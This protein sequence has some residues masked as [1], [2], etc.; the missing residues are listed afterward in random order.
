MKRLVVGVAAAVLAGGGCG[1]DPVDAEGTYSVGITNR[2]NGCNFANWTVGAMTSGVQVVVT[3]TGTSANADVQGG[4][5]F[6]LDVALGSSVFSGRVD[7]A[8]LDLI[9]EGIRP[10]TSG[11]CTYTY[12]AR[13]FATLT[14]DALAGRIEYSAA[15]NNHSDCSAVECTSRQDFSGSRPPR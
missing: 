2:E 8:K 12:D 9:I 6:V 11:N 10:N 4:A 5:G 15:H 14:G 13:L 7:G 3:Q 1:T